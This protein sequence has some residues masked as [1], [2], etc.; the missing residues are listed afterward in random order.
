MLETDIAFNSF[1]L[2]NLVTKAAALFFSLSK[3]GFSYSSKL[4]E[5]VKRKGEEK[6]LFSV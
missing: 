1:S 6:G 4:R 5:R 3:Q 2:L